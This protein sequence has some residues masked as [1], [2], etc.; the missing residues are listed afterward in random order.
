MSFRKV[1]CISISYLEMEIP[2][3]SKPCPLLSLPKCLII[4]TETTRKPTIV[5]HDQRE[6]ESHIVPLTCHMAANLK[7]LKDAAFV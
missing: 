7:T 3:P 4:S 6:N 1:L 5:A 2:L